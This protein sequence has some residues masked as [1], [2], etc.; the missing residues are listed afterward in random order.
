MTTHDVLVPNLTSYLM[1]KIAILV[2]ALLMF[3]IVAAAPVV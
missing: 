3:M 2:L 1:I